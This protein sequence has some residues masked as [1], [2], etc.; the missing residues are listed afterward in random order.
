MKYLL[1]ITLMLALT[2]SAMAELT[3][4]DLEKIQDIVANQVETLKNEMTQSERRL[5]ER[6]SEL[7]TQFNTSLDNRTNGIMII[8]AV[9]SIGFFLLFSAVFLITALLMRR[10]VMK[11]ATMLILSLGCVLF[12][13]TKLPAQRDA[14]FDK[15]VCRSLEVVNKDNE[16]SILQNSDG[17]NIYHRD[18]DLIYRDDEANIP[19]GTGINIYNRDAQVVTLGTYGNG[20]QLV[21]HNTMMGQTGKEAIALRHTHIR[22]GNYLRIN[23]SVSDSFTSIDD[24]TIRARRLTLHDIKMDRSVEIRGGH[25]V[26][27]RGL[28]IY[29][30]GGLDPAIELEFSP[31]YETS[32]K[33][34]DPLSDD[35]ALAFVSHHEPYYDKE[36]QRLHKDTTM[37]G[38]YN[39]VY[40]ADTA[41]EQAITLTGTFMGNT[42]SIDDKFDKD[43]VAFRLCSFSDSP[44]GVNFAVKRDRKTGQLSNW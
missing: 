22:D 26:A 35:L 42:L 29:K 44:T 28:V 1:S 12:Y 15:I 16:I 5:N 8:F 40:I 9:I 41:G 31:K 18:F 3:E 39:T 19:Q 17:I 33:I 4:S 38:N 24:G 2:M 13:A 43:A 14:V 6:I 10:N 11:A 23:S 34:W 7:E 30:P 21:L 20:S 37:P 25:E 27:Q 32:L 36:G